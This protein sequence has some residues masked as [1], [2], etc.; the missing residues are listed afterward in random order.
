[1]T[2]AGTAGARLLLVALAASCSS[3]AVDPADPNPVPSLF[4]LDPPSVV[5]GAA[6]L[7]L[8][9]RGTD[10]VPGSKVRWNGADRPTTFVSD[11]VLTA[12]IAAA[13]LAAPGSASVVVYTGAPGGGASGQLVFTVASPPPLT[14]NVTAIPVPNGTWD[15][16][17]SSAGVV[18]AARFLT[19]SIAR[20]NV[21]TNSV[22]G[23][24]QTGFWPYEVAFNAAGTLAYATN[25]ESNT[26]GVINTT[27]NTQ[28]TT[29][30][31]SDRPIRVVVA[32]AKLYVTLIN[33]DVAVLNASTGTAAGP[34]IPVGGVL[35]GLALTP[36]GSRLRV[37]NTSGL[38]AEINTSTDAMARSI[39]MGGR[40]QDLKVSAD[41]TTLYAANE[42]GWVGVYNLATLART[43][44]IPVTAPFALA[45][46]PAGSQLWVSRSGAGVVTVYYTSSRTV[47]GTVNT[48]GVPRHLA[49]M[50]DGTA[51]IANEVGVVQIARPNP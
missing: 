29:Y 6:A 28:T 34:A 20:I 35:N 26:V 18:Y 27:T 2:F 38:V 19:D 14:W 22:A 32:A 33:G 11:S 5:A 48:G 1:M 41:G 8:T 21:A 43:D 3:S 36:D 31:V 13:D 49:F 44:S 37:S 9:V 30:P 46:N 17:V 50:A 4:S 45:L 23:S 42:A 39:L 15:A 7:T 47:A 40:P 10:F 12:A 25:L 24:F 16:S 51:V